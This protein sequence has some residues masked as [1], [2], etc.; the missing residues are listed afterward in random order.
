MIQDNFQPMAKRDYNTQER[1][2]MAEMGQ[3][4][5]DGSFPIKTRMDL[6]NAIQSVGRASDYEK[7]KRHIIRRARQLNLV[8]MLPQD[9][10]VSKSL[11][12]GNF[13]AD[14]VFRK[15]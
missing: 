7:A 12:T 8:A 15:I 5:P 10:N 4:M 13:S 6:S 2:T 11:W 3:A 14:G 1:Q 9:W